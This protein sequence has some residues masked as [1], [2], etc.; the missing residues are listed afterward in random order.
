[1]RWWWLTGIGGNNF[2]TKTSIIKVYNAHYGKWEQNA[3]VVLFWNGL[4]NSVFSKAVYT[5]AQGMAEVQHAS[6]C[7]ADVHVSGFAL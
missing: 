7:M 5:N 1:M 3:K 6:T 4:L 2:N